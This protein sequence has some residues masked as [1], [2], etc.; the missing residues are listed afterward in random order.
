VALIRS[1]ASL[2]SSGVPCTARLQIL[3]MSGT[4]DDW[5]RRL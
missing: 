3:L 4:S 1:S 5:R 2:W